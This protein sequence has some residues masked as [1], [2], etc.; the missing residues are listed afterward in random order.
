[1][2]VFANFVSAIAEI[3]D[4]ILT[5]YM[6]IIIARALISWVNPDPYNG[7]VQFLYKITEPVLDPLRRLIPAWKMGLDL[8]PMIAILIIMFLKRF[9]VTTLIQMALR[10]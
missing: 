7:I 5:F 1:M 4:Y 2:F 3:V 6:Y 8:S 10:Q 9:I